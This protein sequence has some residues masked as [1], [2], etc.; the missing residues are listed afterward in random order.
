VAWWIWLVIGF[1]CLAAEVL[2]PG[3]IV[4][5]FF[6]AAGLLVGILSGLGLAGPLWVQVLVFS[7]LSVVFLITLRGPIVRRMARSSQDLAIDSLV[8]E[9]A[10]L[11]EDLEPGG[12]GKAELRGTAWTAHNA[13]GA[14]LRK[15]QRCSVTKAQGLN[16][17]LEELDTVAVPP[18]TDGG[19]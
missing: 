4:L 7:V 19:S 14:V 6:G 12:K 2:T 16:L 13:G 10:V 9:E 17:W 8:G 15:G 5:V 3:G 1:A 18:R 11:L